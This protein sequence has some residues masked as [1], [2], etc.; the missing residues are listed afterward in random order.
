MKTLNLRKMALYLIFIALVAALPAGVLA[1]LGD[2]EAPPG[3][4]ISGDP[5]QYPDVVSSDE[6]IAE[7]HLILAQAPNTMNYQGYLTDTSGLA[8]HGTVN[9]IANLY[10]DPAAGVLVW[11]PE[12]SNDVAVVNGLF[13]IVLGA[14][15]PLYPN[16]FDEALF[17][18]L[19][20][21]GTIMPRQPLR[22]SAYALGLIPGAE[23]EGTPGN[24]SYALT[25]NNTSTAAGSRGLLAQGYEYGL[26][27]S[28]TGTGDTAV[29]SPDFIHGR[30]FRSNDDSYVFVAGAGG[31]T[32]DDPA[33]SELIVD[34]Q[35][36]GT[37]RIR[38]R[39]TG[40]TRF[41]YIPVDIPAVLLG[42]NVTVE[43]LVVYYR[44]TDPS[45]FINE[46]SLVKGT[47]A[48]TSTDLLFDTTNLTSTTA[49]TRSYT[50]ADATLD[51][52][53]GWLM[54]R[55]VLF[56]DGTNDSIDIGGVRL[57]LGHR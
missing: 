25:V 14:T 15:T 50:P 29:Y 48:G 38:S 16:M 32:Y 49:T 1:Q 44:V 23:A 52:N 11:G 42:Q 56:F 37:M 6:E 45:S 46:V 17:L 28:E 53:S 39:T 2:D 10:N 36:S 47:G 26:L 3:V 5:A 12:V 40:G 55:F 33:N 8:Y 22:A 35:S 18:G 57:R 31:T 27:A 34:A 24:S 21:N 13:E 51:S 43:Q 54:V 7:P 9:I 20:V 4:P 19:S 30:G 41:F